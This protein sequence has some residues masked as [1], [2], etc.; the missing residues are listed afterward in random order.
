[1]TNY[2]LSLTTEEI[3][4]YQKLLV[5][6]PKALKDLKVIE[7]CEGNLEQAA[8]VLARR[9]DLETVRAGE[10][11]QLA[12]EKARE[13]VCDE[14]FKGGLVPGMVG[15]LVG[16]LTTSATPVLIAVATPVSIYIAQFGIDAFCKVNQ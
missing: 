9:A 16:V 2:P 1:M 8:R 3:A 15:G 12:L 14:K 5:D 4:H 6:N 11:W 7:R 13:I 10:N